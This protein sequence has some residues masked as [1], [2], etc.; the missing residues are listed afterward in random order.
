MLHFSSS[1]SCRS[2]G[3][4]LALKDLFY[5]VSPTPSVRDPSSP[6]LTDPFVCLSGSCPSSVVSNPSNHQKSLPK[7]RGTVCNGQA[8]GGISSVGSREGKLYLASSDGSCFFATVW[9]TA[10]ADLCFCCV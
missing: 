2:F 4:T 5:N 10:V 9:G 3:T 1:S 6:S 7:D 8:R